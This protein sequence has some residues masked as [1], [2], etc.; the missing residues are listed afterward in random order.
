MRAR[1]QILRKAFAIA[2]ATSLYLGPLPQ[3]EAI[4]PITVG[5]LV[6]SALSAMNKPNDINGARIEEIMNELS[7]LE[8]SVES[9]Q[10]ALATLLIRTQDLE[11]KMTASAR[12]A[13]EDLKLV[14]VL[15]RVKTLRSLVDDAQAH[16]DEHFMDGRRKWQYEVGVA[17]SEGRGVRQSDARAIEWFR[18]GAEQGDAQSQA[19]LGMMH[20]SGTGVAQDDGAA[21]DWLEKSA[22]QGFPGALLLLD[23][24]YPDEIKGPRVPAEMVPEVEQL[25]K[26]KKMIG[27]ESPE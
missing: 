10:G 1:R 18:A 19:R 7:A 20:A 8:Q 6:G 4:D 14:N 12:K 17:Y 27:S 13:L 5:I 15:A 21:R 25:I 3:A 23:V 16:G 11:G 2:A 24:L 22:A 9:M 26:L